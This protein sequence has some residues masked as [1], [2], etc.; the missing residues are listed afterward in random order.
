M[1]RK[2]SRKLK[3]TVACALIA[4]VGAAVGGWSYRE[5]NAS[6]RLELLDDARRSSVAFDS[7]ELSRL[8]GAPNDVGTPVYRGVKDRLR[9]LK[10]VDQ[11]VRNVYILRVQPETGKVVFLADATLTGTSNEAVP[12][13]E[14]IQASRLPG[15]QDVMRTGLPITEGPLADALGTWVTAFAII[16][17]A[18][19]NREILGVDVD[20]AGWRR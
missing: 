4:L 6:L 1:L 8:A 13:N 17:P 12:G 18:G 10:T 19:A 2:Y 15:L 9:R 3:L 16:G 11:R 14:F 7:A 20:A 5:R